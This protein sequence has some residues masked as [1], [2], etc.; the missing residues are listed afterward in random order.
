M[1]LIRNFPSRVKMKSHDMNRDG[2]LDCYRIAVAAW[3]EKIIIFYNMKWYVMGR[4]WF[5]G[6]VGMPYRIARSWTSSC[7][8]RR[9]FGQGQVK[10]IHGWQGWLVIMVSAV[11]G[12]AWRHDSRMTWWVWNLK[13]HD[14]GIGRDTGNWDGIG[15]K[16]RWRRW[17]LSDRMVEMGF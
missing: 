12:M 11:S 9:M 5:G 17:M 6:F 1:C 8:T 4:F 2:L 16:W 10:D 14:M 7:Y 15:R 3:W 13:F